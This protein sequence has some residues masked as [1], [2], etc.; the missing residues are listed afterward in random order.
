[1]PA[2]GNLFG[3]GRSAG[4]DAAS[5]AAAS[6][7]AIFA[8]LMGIADQ[9]TG[10][11]QHAD[12]QGLYDPERAAERFGQNYDLQ[13][14]GDQEQSLAAMAH[15]GF[16]PGDSEVAYND[17][18]T[19]ERLMQDELR[20]EEDARHQTMQ[21][22]LAAYSYPSQILGEASGVG[23]LQG[24]FGVQ[25]GQ[26]QDTHDM[27]IFGQLGSIAGALPRPGGSMPSMPSTANVD[28]SGNGMDPNNPGAPYSSSTPKKYGWG[29][30]KFGG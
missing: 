6:E 30:F 11:V 10:Q 12:Q 17:T 21:E 22:K 26:L 24:N 28:N 7:G 25:G 1:M 20:G 15:A 18:K 14:A 29:G 23:A 2:L 3:D 13:H 19:K 4:A 9:I 16:K 27:G 8:K 5:S